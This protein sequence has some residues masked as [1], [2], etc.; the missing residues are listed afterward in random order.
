MA[1]RKRR[2]DDHRRAD[3]ASRFTELVI[4]R[5]GYVSNAGH[6]GADYGIDLQVDT[7]DDDGFLENEPFWIQVK[8]VAKAKRHAGGRNISF[9]LDARDVRYWMGQMLPVILVLYDAEADTLYWAYVQRY[10]SKLPAFSLPGVG[11]SVTIKIETT[12]VFDPEAVRS[13]GRLKNVI[14]GESWGA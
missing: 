9:P 6:P 8:G 3:V 2:T 13:I 14:V 10:F 11:A 5:A 1:D 7:F 4:A 12:D